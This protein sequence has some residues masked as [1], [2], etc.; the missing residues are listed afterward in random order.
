LFCAHGD[1]VARGYLHVIEPYAVFFEIS[2]D[3][4][5]C[6]VAAELRQACC[7]KSAKDSPQM[8]RMASYLL[9][10]IRT[11]FGGQGGIEEGLVVREEENHARFWTERG[12]DA[13]AWTQC[14]L[15][16]EKQRLE[17]IE[18]LFTR[19]V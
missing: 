14:G 9:D 7:G 15:W 10:V 18:R 5:L 16:Q 8:E 13:E 6:F 1:R 17:E 11:P 4:E 3:A 19:S 12:L 2:G